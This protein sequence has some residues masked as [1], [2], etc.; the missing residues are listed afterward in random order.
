MTEEIQ[1]EDLFED[2]MSDAMSLNEFSAGYIGNP[3]VGT[4][5]SFKVKKVVKLVGKRLEGKKKDG[6]TFK[7]NLSNVEYGFEVVTSDGQK[8]TVSSWEVYGKMKNI[9]KKLQK[10][11]GVELQITHICDGMKAENREKD[12]YKVSANV[13]GVFKALDRE[14]NEWIA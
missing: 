5:T 2:D 1:T 13:G 8:Y 9:F 14:T 11:E 10:I 7:K 12:K 4:S 3:P 6:K